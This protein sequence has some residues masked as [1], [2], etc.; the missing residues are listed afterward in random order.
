MEQQLLAI[1]PDA[2]RALG[3]LGRTKIYELIASG[4]LRSVTVGR[5]RFI[6]ASAIT[7]FVSHLETRRTPTG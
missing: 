6:P 4:D 3:G 1:W 5:R 2:G 7:E